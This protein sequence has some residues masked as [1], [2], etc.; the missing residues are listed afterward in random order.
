MNK[1]CHINRKAI[2][3][4]I[5]FFL[6]F[7]IPIEFYFVDLSKSGISIM[8]INSVFAEDK[9]AGNG[10]KQSDAGKNK[11]GNEAKKTKDG[12]EKKQ[13]CPKCPKCP[14]PAKV[15]F[16]GLE[17]KKA[18]IAK[19]EKA[20]KRERKDLD[21]FKEELDDKLDR[22]AKLKKQIE[23]D[24]ANLTKKKTE[25]EQKKQAAFEAK[26]DRLVK[27]YSGMKPKNAAK[28]V[29]KLDLDVAKKIFSRM[30]ETAAAQILSYVD[31]EK[32]AKISECIAHKQQ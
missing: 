30:R 8:D 18:A 16:K 17:E 14:D 11:S 4:I 9:T 25:A 1:Q 31:S 6:I 27:M 19:A 26:M 22:L 29:D 15:I 3:F 23:S 24:L 21:K 32:A 5:I 12:K 10:G 20:L 7:F 28:I 2:I 13:P